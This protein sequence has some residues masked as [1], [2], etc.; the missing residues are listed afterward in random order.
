MKTE[1]AGEITTFY[2]FPI[3]RAICISFLPS[4]SWQK[5]PQIMTQQ[6]LATFTWGAGAQTVSSIVCSDPFPCLPHFRVPIR[7]VN[8][9]G[10]NCPPRR[11]IHPSSRV[12]CGLDLLT[13]YLLVPSHT[14]PMDA[15]LNSIPHLPPISE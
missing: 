11:A 4:A 3:Q 12:A 1:L 6:H 9:P 14:P 15:S 5:Y 8:K 10:R 2:P 7:R 13:V